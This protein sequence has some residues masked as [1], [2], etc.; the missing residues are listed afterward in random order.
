[1]IPDAS[2]ML[3]REMGRVKSVMWSAQEPR[4]GKG[5]KGEAG[6]EAG[7]RLLRSRNLDG[8]AGRDDL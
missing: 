4:P 1:M 7:H 6:K 2:S 5:K 3:D 8:R